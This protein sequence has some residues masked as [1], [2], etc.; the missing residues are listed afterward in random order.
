M[1]FLLRN[2][3]V[4]IKVIYL[5][6]GTMFIILAADQNV[7]KLQLYIEYGLKVHTLSFNSNNFHTQHPPPPPPPFLGAQM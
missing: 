5:D 7:F 6:K 1:V 3:L 2:V 4:H